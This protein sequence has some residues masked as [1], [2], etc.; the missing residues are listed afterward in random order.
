VN[1]P[2]HATASGEQLLLEIHDVA[3]GGKGVARASGKAVFVPWVIDG[4]RVRAQIER[5]RKNFAEARLVAVDT[6]SSHRVEPRCP[7]FGECGG[8]AYQHID[9]R[10][11]LTIKSRQV[12]QTL[13]RLGRFDEVPMRPMI[14][15]PKEYEYRNRIRVHVSEGIVGFYAATG[16]RLIDIE[17]CPISDP[18][19]NDELRQ[20]RTAHPADGDYT[21]RARRTGEYFEQT[22][23][24]VAAALVELV[25]DLAGE[26]GT[27]L[28]DAYCGAGLFGHS[29]AGNFE[30][31]IGM[32]SN[33]RAVEQARARAG[34]NEQYIVADVAERLPDLL[35]GADLESTTLVLDPPAIGLNARLIDAV[36][37]WP[38]ARIIYVS[39]DPA[40]MA[41]D[42]S[43]MRGAFDLR[44]VTP[45]DMFPHTAEIEAVAEL[46]PRNAGKSPKRD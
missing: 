5:S 8:C 23:D 4:E 7:Y 25:R 34:E 43:A 14:P 21:L 24:G 17:C 39:C 22:N 20:I 30:R 29:L 10:H 35:S 42:L 18:A 1:E 41:R 33:A 38:P 36:T 27:L 32:E 15:S 11:Q 40:T 45:L 37:S 26:G 19:V 13:R 9:Y 44:S 3:F 6:A 12:E 28:I 2:V 46:A 16:R 31:M